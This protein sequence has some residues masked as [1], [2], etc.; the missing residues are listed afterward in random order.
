MSIMITVIIAAYAAVAGA[1]AIVSMWAVWIAWKNPRKLL[2][3]YQEIRPNDEPWGGYHRLHNRMKHPVTLMLS[4]IGHGIFIYGGVSSALFWMPN[5]WGFPGED[6]WLPFRTW[7][8]SFI[9]LFGAIAF[10]YMLRDYC[11]LN[12]KERQRREDQHQ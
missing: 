10:T 1:A 11:R 9:A 4:V 8:S 12:F 5:A 7:A 3:V 2:E 6:G